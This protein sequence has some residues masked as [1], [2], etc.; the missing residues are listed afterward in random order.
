VLP[1]HQ[2]PI[3]RFFKQ[4]KCPNCTSEK[5]GRFWRQKIFLLSPKRSSFLEPASYFSRCYVLLPQEG[6]RN[7]NF[8]QNCGKYSL[9]N[10]KIAEMRN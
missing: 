3:C 10:G 2:V 9:R 8:A 5:S 1:N 4:V 6:L 7:A